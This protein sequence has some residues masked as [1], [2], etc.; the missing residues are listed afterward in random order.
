MFEWTDL[1]RFVEECLDSFCYASNHSERVA[2]NIETENNDMKLVKELFL[3]MI[4]DLFLQSFQ[5]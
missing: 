3:V 1:I 4:G 2:E 5:R